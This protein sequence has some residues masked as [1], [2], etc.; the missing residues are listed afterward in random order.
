MGNVYPGETLKFLREHAEELSA[1]AFSAATE[2]LPREEKE[3][4]KT[5]RKAARRS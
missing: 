3:R 5:V 2:K 1:A 4:L